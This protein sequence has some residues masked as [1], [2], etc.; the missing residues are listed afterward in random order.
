MAADSDAVGK[1]V[2][3]NEEPYTVIGVVR[4]GFGFRLS[5]EA[6]DLWKP[7]S[8]DRDTA[9]TAGALRLIARLK[10]G[11]TL[12]AAH[13]QMQVMAADLKRRYHT[14]MGPRG[15]DAGYA[16]AVVPCAK[17]CMEQF[18]RRYTHSQARARFC[19]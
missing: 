4:N 2:R 9:R 18:D 15:E 5:G 7:A 1:L 12:E 17:N 10:R 3:I 11:V 13:A 16:I 19:C 8:L 6:P 14:G